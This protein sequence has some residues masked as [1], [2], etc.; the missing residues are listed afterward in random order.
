MSI[1]PPS[2]ATS[3]Q[4]FSLALDVI[5]DYNKL[6]P[7]TQGKNIIAW[8]PVIAEIVDGFCRFEDKDVRIPYAECSLY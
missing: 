6:R 8:T 7:D 1:K 5:K 3:L 4:G 2:P